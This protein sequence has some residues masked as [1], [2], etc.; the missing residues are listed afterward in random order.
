MDIEGFVRRRLKRGKEPDQIVKELAEAIEEFKPWSY[1]KRREFARA[2]VEEVL[3][4]EYSGRDRLIRNIL[5][6]PEAKVSMGEFG[7]GS[8]GEG[9]FFVHRKIAEIIGRT[10]ALVDATQMDDAGVVEGK[11]EYIAVAVDGMHSRLSDYP[12]LAGF[13][14]ARAAMRD[15]YVMGAEPRALVSDLHLADDGDVGKLF[16]FTAGVSLVGELCSTPLI[17]GSTLRVG[18]DMV[19]GDRLVASVTCVGSCQGKPKVRRD[20]EEGDIILLSEGKG[21]GTI[22]TIAIY[23]GYHHVIPITLNV[24]FM[25]ACQ[26]LMKQGVINRVHALLDVTNGG[27]RGDAWEISLSSG[28]K[29]VLDEEMLYRS[30]APEVMQM[31]QELRI[32]PLGIS[33]DSLFLAVPEEHAGEIIKTL[34]GVTK[35]Y[36]VGV[37]E[38]GRGVFTTAGR[39]IKPKFREAAYTKVKKFVGEE[40]P[41]EVEEM[42]QR[43]EKAAKEAIDKKLM[44]KEFILRRS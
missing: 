2:V 26:R 43:I 15:V 9:D 24:E 34:A 18:G 6:Y 12:F 38:K 19:F 33:T 36:E 37:V 25:E 20:A 1:Q 30:I 23:H 21:G 13:H 10:G 17:G 3:L 5:E 39:E 28:K 44:I 35:V 22:T 29:I 11:A 32:D 16:D 4:T 42:K 41:E 31:L 8:R 7:V 40:S 27:I 14:C